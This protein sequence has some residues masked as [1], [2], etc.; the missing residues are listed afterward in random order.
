MTGKRPMIAGNWKMTGLKAALGEV[1][2]LKADLSG[3][4]APVCEVVLCPPATLIHLVV[5]TLAGSGILVG[6]QDCSPAESGAFTGEVSAAML[7]D[8]GARYVIL[9]HS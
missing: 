6:G 2:K 9:G 1:E 8:L 5:Q 4:G 7:A 3:G